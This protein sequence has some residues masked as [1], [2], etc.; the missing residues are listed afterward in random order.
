LTSRGIATAK[1][2]KEEHNEIRGYQ[3]MSLIF[4]KQKNYKNALLYQMIYAKF[5]EDFFQKNERQ[6]LSNFEAAF[7][8]RALKRN[9]ESIKI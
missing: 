8:L 1:R 6:V 3:I 7:K 4:Q 5:F 2:R 9:K